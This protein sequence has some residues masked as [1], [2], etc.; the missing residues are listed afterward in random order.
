MATTVNEYDV[1]DAVRVTCST[2][3]DAGVPTDPTG[4]TVRYKVAGGTPVVKTYG[5]DSEVV[6]DSSGEFHFDIAVTSDM[7]GALV[8]YRWVATGAV[9][10]ADEKAFQVRQSA[11][12]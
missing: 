7:N 10:G 4:L 1:G 3:T 5:V 6:K 12:Y 11:F 9:A 2:T 8:K